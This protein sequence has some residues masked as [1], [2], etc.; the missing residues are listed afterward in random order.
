MERLYFKINEVSFIEVINLITNPKNKS[1]QNY[2]GL[3]GKI[4]KIVKN[5][6]VSTLI[7]LLN[8]S[9]RDFI[10]PS[11]LKIIRV[12]SIHKKGPVK[13]IVSYK[14]IVPIFSKVLK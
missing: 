9:I 4:I 14:S 13:I 3:N 8:I 2:F 5:N 6:R 10:F 11:V 7:K 12:V 1:S